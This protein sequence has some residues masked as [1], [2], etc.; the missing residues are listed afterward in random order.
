MLL[1]TCLVMFGE[2]SHQEQ[3]LMAIAA[4]ARFA[5]LLE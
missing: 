3:L 5:Q 2:L 1:S 4:A